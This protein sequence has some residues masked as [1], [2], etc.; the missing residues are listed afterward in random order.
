MSTIC[1]LTYADYTDLACR[2]LDSIYSLI[3]SCAENGH[4]YLTSVKIGCNQ[5]SEKL[6]KLCTKFS[7]DIQDKCPS[8]SSSVSIYP[9]NRY[10]WPVLRSWMGLPTSF[11]R[12]VDPISSNFVMWFD[13]DSYLKTPTASW[14]RDVYGKMRDC[15]VMGSVYRS[16]VGDRLDWMRNQSWWKGKELNINAKGN[17]IIEFATGGWWVARTSVLRE[18]NFPPEELRHNGGD[19]LLGAMMYQ[20]GLKLK[21]DRCDVAINADEA[22]NESRS[23]RRGYSENPIGSLGYFDAHETNV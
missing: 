23:I 4:S 3:K 12:S 18:L 6:V 22:G 17:Y 21:H 20:S 10:K 14:L 13:D 2:C 1:V 16:E 9:D 19:S 5:P 11:T 7:I 15:D 8:I